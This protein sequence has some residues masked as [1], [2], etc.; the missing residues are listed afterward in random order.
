MAV[1]ANLVVDQGSSFN[2]TITVEEATGA[3]TNL[4]GYLVR[5]QIRKT[6]TSSVAVDF[7]AEISDPDNGVVVIRLSPAAS[8]ALKAGRYVYDVEIESPS[9]EVTRIIEGQLEVTPRVTRP[10]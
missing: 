1:Y 3:D 4:S 9:E 10:A 5:A 2:T 7:E 6:Y 8:G